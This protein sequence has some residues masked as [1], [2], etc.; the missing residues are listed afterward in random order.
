M[1]QV[2]LRL[3]ELTLAAIDELRGNVPRNAWISEAVDEKMA[4]DTLPHFAEQGRRLAAQ[5]ADMMA[6]D[7]GR[8]IHV[9]QS[10]DPC[11]LGWKPRPGTARCFNC[12]RS[13]SKHEGAHQ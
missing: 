8:L 1:K 5:R 9:A 6:Q 4:R 10:D 13:I 3:T 7:P 12:G 2:N 11:P